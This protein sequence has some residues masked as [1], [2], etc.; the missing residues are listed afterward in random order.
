MQI[1]KTPEKLLQANL[2]S[3]LRQ[4][5]TLSKELGPIELGSSFFC[6]EYAPAIGPRALADFGSEETSLPQ[7]RL[8]VT[9]DFDTGPATDRHQSG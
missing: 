9:D 8:P 2:P 1:R 6:A 5:F 7:P 3:S 4:T